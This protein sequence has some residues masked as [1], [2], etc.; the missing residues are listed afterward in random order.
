MMNFYLVKRRNH[1]GTPITNPE[2]IRS[3]ISY[4]FD[5]GHK[6]TVARAFI[7][8]NEVAFLVDAHIYEVNAIGFYFKGSEHDDKGIYYQ[9]WIYGFAEDFQEESINMQMTQSHL[10][11][12]M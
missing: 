11:E 2:K 12:G 9:E 4:G 7:N 3:T 6:E 8:N 5:P 10:F 1:D